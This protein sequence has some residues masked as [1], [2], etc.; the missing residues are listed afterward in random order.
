MGDPSGSGIIPP[1]GYNV[2]T[3]NSY[4]ELSDNS[5]EEMPFQEVRIKRKR[6]NPITHS[7][8][9]T[10]D[11]GEPARKKNAISKTYK[12]PPIKAYNLNIKIVFKELVNKLNHNNFSIK[13][14][15]KDMSIIY[16]QNLD[17]YNKCKSALSDLQSRYYTY[18]P[19]ELKP[20]SI[21][22]KGIHKTYDEEDVLPAINALK[23]PYA[24]TK[25]LKIIKYVTTKS[26]QENRN[27]SIYLVQ[28]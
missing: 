7:T 15:N 3:Y 23:F 8:R 27:L 2:D 13:N 25:V 5:E 17:D 28:I 6:S 24:L 26:K 1:G 9:N 11:S 21:L 18:T 12:M 22:L 14:A 19:E 16:T 4:S 10:P 20:I